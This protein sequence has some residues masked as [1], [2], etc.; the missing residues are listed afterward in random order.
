MVCRQKERFVPIG[1][2]TSGEDILISSSE[3]DQWPGKGRLRSGGEEDE[4]GIDSKGFAERYLL[5]N[6][7]YE[8]P[9]CAANP[10]TSP[11]C[12]QEVC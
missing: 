2:K 12:N 9:F 5:E 1:E 11:T 8:L 3:V 6:F 7:P 4:G 10:H